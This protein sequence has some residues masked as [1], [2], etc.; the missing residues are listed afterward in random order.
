MSVELIE[1]ITSG[2]PIQVRELVFQIL[3]EKAELYLGEVRQRVVAEMVS[4]PFE[5]GETVKRE[6][7]NKKSIRE[8]LENIANNQ[9]KLTENS[10]IRLSQ[11][12]I[13]HLDGVLTQHGFNQTHAGTT[14]GKYGAFYKHPAGHTASI[15][16][17]QDY[18]VHSA[19]GGYFHG[20]GHTEL[21]HHMQYVIKEYR[22]D[23]DN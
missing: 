4:K 22:N 6:K 10:N 14:S 11:S 15:N 2:T 1:K 18:H 3:D 5:I 7:W 16:H 20:N 23:S 19:S 21:K 8:A 9:E 12:K 13:K 17:D